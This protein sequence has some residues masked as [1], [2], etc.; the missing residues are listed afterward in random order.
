MRHVLPWVALL[1][2][3][4]PAR[5]EEPSLTV[6]LD[7]AETVVSR[8]QLEALAPST[9]DWSAHGASF[10]LRGV[11]LDAVLVKAGFD[12]GPKDPH[13]PPARKRVGLR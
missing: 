9:F 11:P 8:A 10:K 3:S 5:G 13:V 4:L 2:I 12:P 6:N 1:T 7:G